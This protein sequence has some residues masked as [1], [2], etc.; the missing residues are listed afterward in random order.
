MSKSQFPVLLDIHQTQESTKITGRQLSHWRPRDALVCGSTPGGLAPYP[1]ACERTGLLAWVPLTLEPRDA[2]KTADLQTSLREACR[3]G[4]HL[5]SGPPGRL[6]RCL[7]SARTQTPAP[8]P[9]HMDPSSPARPLPAPGGGAPSPRR[10]AQCPQCPRLCHHG[11]RVDRRDTGSPPHRLHRHV[12]LRVPASHAGPSPPA[13][14]QR[15]NPAAWQP[16]RS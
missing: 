9:P 5:P 6:P 14:T 1:A 7:L 2:G 4:A 11:G 15:Q 13:V 3:S 8:P 12:L 10:M 16:Q